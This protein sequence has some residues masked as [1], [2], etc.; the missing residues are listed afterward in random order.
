MKVA[1]EDIR[2]GLRFIHAKVMDA[3]RM[4][5]SPKPHQEYEVTKVAN[6]MVYYRAVYD[7]GTRVALGSAVECTTLDDFSRVVLSVRI[8]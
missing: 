4:D 8:A 1:D 3:M 5:E 2:K 6:G 7:Y